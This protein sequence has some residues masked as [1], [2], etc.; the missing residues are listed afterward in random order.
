MEKARIAI[1]VKTLGVAGVE[2]F[3]LTLANRLSSFYDVY[4]FSLSRAKKDLADLIDPAVTV[5][6]FNHGNGNSPA[7][8]LEIAKALRKHR[9]RLIITNNYSTFL[10]GTIP[11]ILSGIKGRFHI[12]H[13]FETY[14]N[15][16][17]RNYKK[18]LRDLGR[19]AIAKLITRA[20]S[21]SEAGRDYLSVKWRVPCH[22]VRTI[23]N[24]VNVDHFFP[25]NGNNISYK[26]SL[27]F[28][29]D[30]FV[31]GSVCR[32]VPVKN[33]EMMLHAAAR[34]REEIPNLRLIILGNFGHRKELAEFYK[35]I[36]H[37]MDSL[38]LHD[39]VKFIPPQLDVGS[40][41]RGFDIYLNTSHSEGLSM[42]I[43]EA[44]AS[45]LPVIATEV[46][47]NSELVKDGSNG[48][49]ISP[50]QTDDL[51]RA[52]KSLYADYKLRSEFAAQSRKRAE[53]IFSDRLMIDKY[54]ILINE[55]IC[56]D[57]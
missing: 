14:L 46:G 53:E 5:L 39:I 20:I 50:N 51:V 36:H 31:L 55:A 3:V 24:G 8:L 22:K 42:A 12:Q 18:Y 28:D 29:D 2:R 16:A 45:G 38:K 49:L 44:M 19:I 43:I 56:I 47:G 33:V 10:E 35:K 9:I 13:G 41:L 32:V 40:I 27:G 1:F 11:A 21:V 4:I 54:R 25:A 7:L 34:L 48:F 52:I 37:L 30:A 57:G 6:N 15:Y 17:G 26:K 23:Y